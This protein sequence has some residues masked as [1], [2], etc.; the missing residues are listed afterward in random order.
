MSCSELQCATMSCSELQYVT[1]SHS[2]LQCVVMTCSK[3]QCVSMRQS[4]LQWTGA[5]SW[6]SIFGCCSTNS[7]VC[8]KPQYVDVAVRNSVFVF[9]GCSSRIVRICFSATYRKYTYD[10]H[11]YT[12]MCIYVSHIH[13]HVYLQ[14]RFLYIYVHIW[15]SRFTFA[16]Q[17]AYICTYIYIPRCHIEWGQGLFGI[18]DCRFV[19][20]DL[21]LKLVPLKHSTPSL[22]RCVYFSFC[23][24]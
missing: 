5:A 6:C 7:E 14:L 15:T 3:L 13:I 1:M 23:L 11:I 16:L 18:L 19:K 2:E 9:C 12:Y 20:Q 21:R 8:C 4:E 24:R 10:S 17:Y 22:R